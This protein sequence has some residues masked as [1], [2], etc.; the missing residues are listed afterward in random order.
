MSFLLFQGSV[1]I[2]VCSVAAYFV[3]FLT[4]KTGLRRIGRAILTV[5]FLLHTGNI[6]ARA[7][8]TG[9]TPITSHHETVTF[10]AWSV[11]CCYLSF[12]WRYTVKNLGI[13]VSV[14]VLVLM[15]IAAFSS[16]GTIPLP[17]A[18]QSWWLPVHA[19]ITLFADGFLALACIGGIMYLLQEREIKKKRFGLF[20]SRLPSLEALDK[21]NHHCLSIGFPLFTLGLITGSLWAKQAWGAYWHWD[22]KETWSLITWFLYAAAV[23]QR[24]TVGW[25]GRRVAI[26]SIIAFLSVLFTL[27]G[28]SFLL[29]GIHTYVA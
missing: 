20:Y 1:A 26:L 28:V 27:W 13:F 23:H 8:E 4:Q 11:A 22:P 10:F 9:H 24:F 19:S 29:Q 5:A 3:F 16:R 15:L 7:I 12:R 6:I 21:L 17:P 14:F 25:R 18:L 2:Y